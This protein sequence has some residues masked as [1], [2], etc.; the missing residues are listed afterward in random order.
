MKILISPDYGSSWSNGEAD[1]DIQM[2]MLTYQPLIEA[3][4]RGD[5]LTKGRT[6]HYSLFR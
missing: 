1:P 2:F 3:V 6:Q 5:E 4:E